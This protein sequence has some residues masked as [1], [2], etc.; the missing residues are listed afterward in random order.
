[1]INFDF[2]RSN[3]L[4]NF[5]QNNLFLDIITTFSICYIIYMY[6]AFFGMSN[7]AFFV[8]FLFKLL[9]ALVKE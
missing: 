3:F 7:W 9:D 2:N 6:A 5:L 8:I 1:M 4:Y